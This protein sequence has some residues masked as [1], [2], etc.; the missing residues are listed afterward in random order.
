L[1][2]LSDELNQQRQDL[3]VHELFQYKGRGG[4]RVGQARTS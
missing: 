1:N 2:G 3:F 4:A